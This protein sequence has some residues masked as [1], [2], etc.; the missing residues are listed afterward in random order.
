MMKKNRRRLFISNR[1]KA[2]FS[3]FFVLSFLV[4]FVFL[5]WDIFL[6]YLDVNHY[7]VYET[8]YN[9]H[10]GLVLKTVL[11]IFWIGFTLFSAYYYLEGKYNGIFARMDRLFNDISKGEEKKLFFRDGDSFAYVAE[12]FN[13]MVEN[14]RT[15]GYIAQQEKLKEMLNKLEELS[16]KDQPHKTEIESIINDIKKFL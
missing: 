13:R 4:A 6:Q 3:L 2:V 5:G 11:L 16:K 14:L 12:S 7:E 15:Q 8:L 10:I 1:I 9:A